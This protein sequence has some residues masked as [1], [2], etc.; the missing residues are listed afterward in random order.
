MPCL[1]GLSGLKEFYERNKGRMVVIGISCHDHEERWRK[2][3]QENHLPW[4]NVFAPKN[5]KVTE[6][7]LVNAFPTLVLISPDGRILRYANTPDSDIYAFIQH[8]L[9]GN[10]PKESTP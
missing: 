9:D 6:D 7:Y 3:V 8:L 10:R 5:C 2:A 1:K 4:H